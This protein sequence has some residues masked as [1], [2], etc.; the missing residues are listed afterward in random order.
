MRALEQEW[1]RLFTK[2]PNGS[3]FLS[4]E[5]MWT[6]WTIYKD[7]NKEL[8]IITI[9]DGDDKL[10][11][12]APLIRNRYL[13][14]ELVP[15][16]QIRFMGTGEP[17][18]DEVCSEYLDFLV[19]QDYKP[20]P[21]IRSVLQYLEEFV[22][23]WDEVFFEQLAKESY[24]AKCLD[25]E[26]R[27]QTELCGKS[28]Y[29]PLPDT[30]EKL[31]EQLSSN[32]RYR[33]RKTI[34]EGEK[35]GRLKISVAKTVTDLETAF[36]ILIELH[37]KAWKARGKSGVFSSPKFREFHRQFVSRV[38]QK[39]GIFL[40]VLSID[41][42]P[43]GAVYCFRSRNKL[44]MYQT[45]FDIDI[46]KKNNKLKPGMTAHALVIKAA[47][48]SGYSEYDFMLGDQNNY[49]GQWTSSSRD[50]YQAT[51]RKKGIKGALFNMVNMVK[52][53]NENR[54]QAGTAHGKIEEP[55]RRIING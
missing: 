11:C 17:E 40:A 34:K 41:S 8:C 23:Q 10:I 13:W 5:W 52:R 54:E 42:R 31:L 49:K 25:D 4:W 30:W 19:D 16:N 1:N 12:L 38:F 39:N 35:E 46:S 29:L 24:L 43:I 37:E 55:G 14:K 15:V 47:I 32:Q 7:Q 18:A 2:S 3:V 22:F 50:I 48:A 26:P 21:L 33:I 36:K 44:L 20:E 45:G 27:Y 28:Y 9:R 6:W 53:L 51:R